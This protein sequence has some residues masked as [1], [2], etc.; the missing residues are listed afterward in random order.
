[1]RS[2]VA[3]LL[4]HKEM[5]VNCIH[6]TV[7]ALKWKR[8]INWNSILNAVHSSQLVS[9][10]EDVLLF[11]NDKTSFNSFI[12]MMRNERE[13]IDDASPSQY[14][15]HL[16]QLLACCT[17]GKNVY[18]EIKCHSLLPLDDIVRVV[19]HE[20]CVPE[21]CDWAKC[22]TNLRLTS[23]CTVEPIIVRLGKIYQISLLLA[24][25]GGTPEWHHLQ[26]A[27]CL[28]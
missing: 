27:R 16:V 17:E 2:V 22:C 6:S 26:L 1:M 7:H 20:D 19:T 24:K 4:T 8:V 5:C 15:I 12:G 3:L 21:V 28:V 25:V 18:T 10:G 9:A 14:H 11:Y 13:R 23:I